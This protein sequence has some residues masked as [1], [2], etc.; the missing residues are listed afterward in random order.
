MGKIVKAAQPCLDQAKCCS[1]DALQ[2]YEDGSSFCFSCNTPF[3]VPKFAPKMKPKKDPNTED[4]FKVETENV[5]VEE[6]IAKSDNSKIEEILTYPIRGFKERDITKNVCEFY[7]VRVTYNSAGEID[8]HYYPYIDGDHVS[9][10]VRKLPKIFSYIGGLKGL[11]G[12][13]KF[14]GGGK[15]LVITEGELDAMSIAKAYYDKYQKFYPVISIPSATLVKKLLDDREWLRS[16]DEVI[17]CFDND[18]AGQEATSQAIRIIG[19]DKVKIA[20]LPD[21][22]PNEVL[23]KHGGSTLLHCIWDAQAWTPAGIIGKEELWK[24]LSEYNDKIAVP[25]PAC[26][27]GL[28]T[29]IKG[30]REGEIALFISGT[31]CFTKGTEILMIDGSK[32]KV[33]DISIGDVIMGDDNLPR[34]VLTLFRGMEQMYRISIRGGEYFNCNESHILSLVNN[35]GEGRWGL[36]KDEIVDV[37]LSDYLKW[38]DKRKHLSKLFKVGLVEFVNDYESIIHP[39]VLGVWLGDGYSAGARLSNEGDQILARLETYGVSVINHK[40]EYSW[41]LSDGN[42]GG[43]K[44]KLDSLG[45][46]NNKHIPEGYLCSSIEN[47]L[48]LLAGLLD[49]DGSYDSHN[50]GYEFSQKSETIT[51]Q[52]I[53]LV[54]S[55][56]F[57]AT[58]GKQQNNKFGNCFRV[59]VSGDGLEE[60]P[61]ALNRKKAKPRQQIKNPLRF[62]PEITKLGIDEFYGFEVDGNGRFVLGNF[63]VTH[64]SG[65]STI[66]REI[67]LDTLQNTSKDYKVGIVSLEESP[68]ETSRKL[69]GM[70]INRNPANEEVSLEDLKVGFDAVFGEDRVLLLDHQGSIDDG[71]IVD[72]LEYMCLMG[73]KEIFLDHLTILVSEGSGELEGNAAIDKIMNDLLRLVK[74][75]PVWIG[76]VSHLR[77]APNGKQ[78][79]EEG[80]LP[81]IDDIKGCLAINTGVI[82]SDGNVKLVQDIKVGDVLIGDDGTPRE[83]LNLIRGSQQMYRVTMKTSGDQFICNEDHI[84]TLSYNDK[85]FDISVKAFL[86]TSDSYRFRCK[87]HYSVGYELPKKELLIPPYSLGVW[88]GD[89]SKS[90][91]RIMDASTLGIVDRVAKEINAKLSPPNDKNHEYFNFVTSE[92]GEMLNK[93]KSLNVY[94]N[95]HIPTSYKYSSIEDRL[96][97]LAGLIDTDGSYSTR[98]KTFCFYQ[99][100]EK[101]ANDVKKIARSV[102]LYS[103]IRSQLISGYYSSNG[104]IIFQVLISGDI[105]KIPT[106]KPNYTSRYTNPLK[107]GVIIEKLDIQDYYGFTLSGNGRFLLDNHIVTHNSGSIKQISFDIIAFSR[108]MTNEDEYKRNL[109]KI[110]CLKSRT[111]GLT[112]PCLGARYDNTTGRLTAADEIPKEEFTDL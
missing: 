87:Q 80:K 71:S 78:S 99:K 60:I 7:D 70:Y 66:L 51:D 48:Q 76:L 21:K 93:L 98:D 2:I 90:A 16:F 101:L 55:L 10:K 105:N 8:A 67:I 42:F 107:R 74:K 35:D 83:V 100:D 31:G 47:R 34:N 110:S 109:I 85:M 50:N 68:A 95:K 52:F 53:R 86:K 36:S 64:N 11:F 22:D 97:L 88:L 65:K 69:S 108:D 57:Q 23:L 39:Y 106:Q 45:L 103:S 62:K 19:V 1:S 25:Y 104:S 61:V 33:E 91:F 58:K 18:K 72:M 73:C 54:N 81:T 49:T 44:S 26:L 14:P 20:K 28:N 89:G 13:N 102:G 96:E 15:R 24:Q 9:Y 92:K 111:T 77:K 17:L 5:S 12:K 27:A 46:I 4:F 37:K 112:G 38:S 43:L 59:W 41:G 63:I 30:R 29:K 94:E 84:L 3:N 56:G 32:K 79:F 40:T 6:G 75:H 82:L